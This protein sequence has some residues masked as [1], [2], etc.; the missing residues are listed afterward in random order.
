M[1]ALTDSLPA[2]VVI[3]DP[4]N[5][6]TDCTAGIVSAL[7]GGS[8]ISLSGAMLNA[9]ATC[10]VSVD[11]TGTSIGVHANTTGDLT[12]TIGGPSRSGGKRPRR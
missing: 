6:T 11:V 4:S 9:G 3:A 12:S 8:T 7:V 1:I 2:G 5:A 10:T